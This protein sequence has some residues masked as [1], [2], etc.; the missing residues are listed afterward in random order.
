MARRGGGEA[1]RGEACTNGAGTLQVS[2]PLHPTISHPTT[3]SP[4]GLVG[5]SFLTRINSEL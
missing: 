2:R 4:G 3:R 5:L 1:W